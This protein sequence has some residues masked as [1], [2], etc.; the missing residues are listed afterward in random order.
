MPPHPPPTASVR[1]ARSAPVIRHQEGGTSAASEAFWGYG[2][3]YCNE[4]GSGW[5][6][7]EPR[8]KSWSRGVKGVKLKRS[9]GLG[10]WMPSFCLGLLGS[11][12][13]LPQARRQQ[14]QAPAQARSPGSRPSRAPLCPGGSGCVQRLCYH[15]QVC[16]GCGLSCCS[17]GTGDAGTASSLPCVLPSPCVPIYPPSDPQ[18]CGSH[19]C[20]GELGRGNFLSYGCFASGGLKRR[21]KEGISCH[22]EADVPAFIPL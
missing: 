20:P 1:A 6:P 22:H 7:E 18:M 21:D 5:G 12:A 13:P 16:W 15:H 2:H 4:G 3:C 10:S 19:W 14:S 11:Q 17:R 9:Q 8:V